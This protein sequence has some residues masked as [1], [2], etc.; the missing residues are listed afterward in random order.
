MKIIVCIYNDALLNKN[1]GLMTII[2]IYFTNIIATIS[3]WLVLTVYLTLLNIDPINSSPWAT[4]NFVIKLYVYN[5]TK[6]L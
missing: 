2:G 6:V 3:R 4:T 5:Y 1:N